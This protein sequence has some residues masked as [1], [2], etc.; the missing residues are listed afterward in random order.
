M[1][2]DLSSLEEIGDF[3]EDT[4]KV[5]KMK[6]LVIAEKPIAGERIAS[7]L[8]N[9]F[10]TQAERREEIYRIQQKDVPIDYYEIN[11]NDIQIFV[12]SL[13]GHLVQPELKRS[14]NYP[15]FEWYLGVSTKRSDR[16]RWTLIKEL[17]KDCFIVG[18]TDN[19]E[20][21]E[22][23]LC[24]IVQ[25]LREDKIIDLQPERLARMRFVELTEQSIV[26]A[27]NEAIAGRKYISMRMV[28]AGHWRHLMDLWYGKNI[29]NLFSKGAVRH[30]AVSNIKFQIGRVK[31]PMLLYLIQD[32]FKPMDVPEE[33]VEEPVK[34]SEEEPEYVVSV[35]VDYYGKVE[36][37]EIEI[38]GDEI[39]RLLASEWR[40]EVTDYEDD[41]DEEEPTRE[42][43]NTSDILKEA[44]NHGISV[45]RA[46][47]I[48]QNLYVF[49][50]ISY[51]RTDSRKL[52]PEINYN[53]KIRQL[54]TGFNWID[55][56]DFEDF[57]TLT[58]LHASPDEEHTGI[59]PTGK[60]PPE[61]LPSEYLL[62]WELITRKFLMAM[63]KPAKFKRREVEVVVY[64][65]GQEYKKAT[66]AFREVS[67]WGYLKYS[68]R[69]E[70]CDVIPDV[71]IGED[72]KV[73]LEV[74]T[75]N[76]W[77]GSS[78]TKELR[79]RLPSI[80]KTST[81]YLFDWM[82][83]ERLGTEAT[84]VGHIGALRDWKYVHGEEELNLTGIGHKLAVLLRKYIP[85]SVNDTKESYEVMKLLKNGLELNEAMEKVE[86]RVKEIYESTNV[87]ELGRE[88][89][90]V[91]S[92]PICGAKARLIFFE[93]RYDDRKEVNY[94]IGCTTYP[95]CKF[96]LP[97]A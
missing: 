5:R 48:L 58:Q 69:N 82:V 52:D 93:R 41:E 16:A 15:K 50:Y 19:D 81:R 4:K 56:D 8:A 96:M 2:K 22:V 68:G 25:K 17:A 89:N 1:V 78:Y 92:C 37:D 21:G 44:S 70:W 57:F 64:K 54:S 36:V 60:I 45:E 86:Q 23:M 13:I 61:T 76:V 84:R 59:Y 55:P 80:E 3:V 51:P 6:V 97:Y 7:F 79:Q 28:N 91:G 29:S 38:K 53:E 63:A 65:D 27:F 74:L 49:G 35:C 87:D 46:D 26:N 42:V 67:E 72:T 30:G 32:S 12:V 95:S 62:M 88:L 83:W 18:A 40:A 43:Y 85:I 31:I 77:F 33:Q 90:S 24:Y 47:T 9:H 20:E 71:S 34:E 66:Q 14:G 73:R 94:A 10:S 11:G 39:S 75:R